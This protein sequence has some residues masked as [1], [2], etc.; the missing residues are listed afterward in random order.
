[1][2]SKCLSGAV[3]LLLSSGIASAQPTTPG[4]PTSVTSAPVAQTTPPGAPALAPGV[5]DP[6]GQPIGGCVSTPAALPDGW[7]ARADGRARIWGS[8]EYLLWHVNGYNV[9][10]LVTTGPA[11]FPVGVL[12]SPGTQVIAGG[13]DIAEDW[14]S[15]A[16]FTI[17]AWVHECNRLGIEADYFF[18]CERNSG[19]SF[20]LPVLAR[21]F[22]S[23]NTGAPTSEFAAFPGIATGGIAIDAPTELW[24]FGVR[25]RK[26]LCCGCCWNV[27]L[28]GGFQ[29]LSLQESLTITETGTF[30]ANAPFPE[31]AGQTFVV[32][33]RFATEN[34]FYGGQ[35][36]VES[37]FRRGAW[38]FGLRALVGLGITHQEVDIQ[39][40]QVVTNA[41][42]QVATFE[43]GLL[44]LPGANIGRVER[45]VFSVVPQVGLNLGYQVTERITLFAGYSLLY[46]SNVVRPGDQI[47]MVLDVNRIPNFERNPN[48]VVPPRPANPFKQSDLWV[49]GLNAG[50]GFNW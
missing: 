13:S 7:N 28:L 22:T 43:G 17:G 21:P 5:V 44:A 23:G 15:G 19:Q 39:G 8:A 45:D 11:Q 49:H 29:Y 9:P 41:A 33:D 26:P 14:Y 3:A 40:S 2:R 4:N 16:R 25:L 34:T 6:C 18:L 47:D 10:P 12:G 48:P 37:W 27:D 42:G 32:T 1:M 20:N 31:L 50:V 35:V 38:M 36:G 24:G 30:A 46:W